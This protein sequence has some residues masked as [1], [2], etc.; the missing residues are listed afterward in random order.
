MSIIITEKVLFRFCF[1]VPY[2]EWPYF[3][4]EEGSS[5]EMKENTL[6]FK[7]YDKIDDV[8]QIENIFRLGIEKY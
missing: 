4:R 7:V 8:R 6:T 2:K 5:S 1:F 3:E